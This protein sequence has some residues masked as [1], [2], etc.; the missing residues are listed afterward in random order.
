[1]IICHAGTTF[2]NRL[3]ANHPNS[4]NV[5]RGSREQ[6]MIEFMDWQAPNFIKV[7]QQ[8]FNYTHNNW[9]LIKD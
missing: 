4:F 8:S 7:A 2:S 9:Q 5:I 6:L 1:V 3:L